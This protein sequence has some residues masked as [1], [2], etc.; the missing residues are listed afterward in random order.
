MA[1]TYMPI[2]LTM[3]KRSTLVV[4]GG[5]VALRKIDTLLD[6]DTTITVIAPAVHEKLEYYAKSGRITLETRDYHSPEAAAFGLVIAATD[7]KELNRQISADCRGAGVLVN[8]VDDPAYCDFIFPAVVRRDCLTAAVAT[9][10]QAPFIAGHLRLILENVFPEHWTQLMRYATTFRKQ[11]QE[12]WGSDSEKK[13]GC[14]SRFLEADWKTMLKEKDKDA[15][16]WKLAAIVD[17]GD[18]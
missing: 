6:Y 17:G 3:K 18:A 14:Y 4:G 13:Q 12:R 1:N 15:I 8:V 16:E 2:T 5:T 10:G 9:D 11:V 7:N